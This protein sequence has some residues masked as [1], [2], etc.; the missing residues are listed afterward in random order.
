M[1]MIMA[2]VDAYVDAPEGAVCHMKKHGCEEPAKDLLIL[3]NGIWVAYCGEHTM[4]NMKWD[5]SRGVFV[6][7]YEEV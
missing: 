5:D 4:E 2:R 3:K 6:A 1:K 7:F